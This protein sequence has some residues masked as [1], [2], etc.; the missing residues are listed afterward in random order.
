MCANIS[1]ILPL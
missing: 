1:S